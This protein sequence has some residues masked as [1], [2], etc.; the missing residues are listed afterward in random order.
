MRLTSGR[1]L[2]CEWSRFLVLG[3]CYVRFS[4]SKRPMTGCETSVLQKAM[5]R[6]AIDRV[7]R[8]LGAL[9]LELGPGRIGLDVNIVI[10]GPGTSPETA[11]EDA[12]RTARYA[13]D[14][15]SRHGIKV[16]L[17]LHPYYRGDRGAARFPRPSALF[18]GD[19]GTSGL[20]DRR[21]GSIDGGRHVN[22]YRL[23]RRGPRPRASAARPRSRARSRCV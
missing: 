3:S 4:A 14:L 17:N 21:L 18:A 12:V 13:L 7:Y 19:D 8:D 1:Q 16:D 2:S 23:A 11:V 6:A 15:G 9:G 22:L 5:P 20:R 10:A